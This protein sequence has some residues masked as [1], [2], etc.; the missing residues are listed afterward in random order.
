[1]IKGHELASNHVRTAAILANYN[2]VLHH[3]LT[4][5]QQHCHHRIKLFNLVTTASLLIGT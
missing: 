5:F 2:R 1:M 4:K 3:I